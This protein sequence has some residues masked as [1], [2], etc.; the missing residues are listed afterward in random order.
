MD[1]VENII[2]RAYQEPLNVEYRQRP[3]SHDLSS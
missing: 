3:E 2:S 1:E